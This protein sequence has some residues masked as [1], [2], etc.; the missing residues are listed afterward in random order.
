MGA[1][2]SIFISISTLTL[3]FIL[4][5]TLRALVGYSMCESAYFAYFAAQ[6]SVPGIGFFVYKI[7]AISPILAIFVGARLGY[8]SL[9]HTI[10]QTH[11]F[12]L[13]HL[14]SSTC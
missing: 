1:Y 2:I 6:G 4:I 9:D 7:Y 11:Y 13:S 8:L 3:T 12:Q 14:D 5:F 10:T